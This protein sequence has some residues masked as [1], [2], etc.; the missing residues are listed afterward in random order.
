[1]RN[2][3]RKL[4]WTY[5]RNKNRK[6]KRWN[7]ECIRNKKQIEIMASNVLLLRSKYGVNIDNLDY[8]IINNF[9]TR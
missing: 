1:M 2:K 9:I 4:K 6:Y 8:Y 7:V 5:K 3:R